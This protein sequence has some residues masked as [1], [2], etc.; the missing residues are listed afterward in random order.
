M[1]LKNFFGTSAVGNNTVNEMF[2]RRTISSWI[3][4]LKLGRII[5]ALFGNPTC[6]KE[7]FNNIEILFQEML[8]FKLPFQ[9]SCEKHE[10]YF[11]YYLIIFKEYW[12]HKS[13]KFV[14]FDTIG[15]G[16]G[17]RTPPSQGFDPLPTRRVP[18]LYTFL[19]YSFLAD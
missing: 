3:L 10:F 16:G 13:C 14:T 11:F 19:R 6:Q 9:Y 2:L 18:P 4:P 8:H 17:G 7:G 15:F 5:N 1:S 12:R